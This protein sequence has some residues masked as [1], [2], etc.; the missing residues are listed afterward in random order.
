MCP[1]LPPELKFSPRTII[2]RTV[3]T[4]DYLSYIQRKVYISL[5]Q[6]S[7]HQRLMRTIPHKAFE[8][9]F[10]GT[11]YLTARNPGILEVF[12]EDFDVL[13]FQPGSAQDLAKKIKSCK[14][15][16]DKLKILSE[17]FRLTYGSV[18][19]QRKLSEKFLEIA[20]ML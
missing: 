11:P 12:T 17:N 1:G 15:D 13:C 3:Y 6:L 18:L 2:D 20:M 16:L 7:D 4:K 10:F 14:S 9:A 19:Q 5:G 8:S